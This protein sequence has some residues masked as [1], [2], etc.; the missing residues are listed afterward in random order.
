MIS[1]IKIRNYAIIDELVLDWRN[2]FIVI[3]GETGAGKSILFNAIEL[4]MGGR[5]NIDMIRKGQDK[6]CIE[7]CLHL[8]ERQQQRITPILEEN[9][10]DWDDVLQIKRVLCSSGRNRVYING[11]RVRLE[12]LKTISNGLIDIVSQHANQTLLG[13]DSRISTEFN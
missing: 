5:A 3:T 11:S 6:A 1:E 2:G 13:N 12:V 9:D 10:C 8:T 7:L 4:C